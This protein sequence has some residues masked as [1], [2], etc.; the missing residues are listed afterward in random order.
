MVLNN[1]RQKRRK[2]F[3]RGK[4]LGEKINK[5]LKELK[6]E[7][8]IKKCKAKEV[9]KLRSCYPRNLGINIF[10]NWVCDVFRKNKKDLC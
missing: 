10:I 8:Q 5:R 2:T 4:K 3:L 7:T 1:E 6:G 9:K